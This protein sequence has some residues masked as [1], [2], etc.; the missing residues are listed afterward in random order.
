ME[1]RMSLLGLE[2]QHLPPSTNLSSFPEMSCFFWFLS[3]HNDRV[4]NSELSCLGT[5]GETVRLKI[6]VDL[7]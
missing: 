4:L 2:G 1:Y 6:T 7:C 5:K 3:Q